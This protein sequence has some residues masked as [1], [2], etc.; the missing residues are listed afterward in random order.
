[1]TCT[2]GPGAAIEVRIRRVA[3]DVAGSADDRIRSSD[4]RRRCRACAARA[5]GVGAGHG[6]AEVGA[7]AA[8][9][10]AAAPGMGEADRLIAAPAAR[11]GAER[12]PVLGRARDRGWRGI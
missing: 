4:D 1:M 5:G 10:I 2:C 11:A 3:C 8:T 12:L 9:A 6:D 7:A